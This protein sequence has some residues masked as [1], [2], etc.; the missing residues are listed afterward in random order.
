MNAE[1]KFKSLA[2]FNDYFRDEETCLAHFASIRFVNGEICPH[3]GHKH[4]HKFA[5]GKRYRCADCKK[6]FTIK[7]GT[8][9]G[10][11][12]L[13]LRK[14]FM[15]IYLLSTTSKGMSSVQLAKHV[16][17]TQTATV[18]TCGVTCGRSSPTC[19]TGRWRCCSGTSARSA[20]PPGTGSACAPTSGVAPA[21][22]R[23]KNAS[24]PEI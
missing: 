22:A 18:K 23:R 17:V 7:T 6:D 3:C 1:F 9:F 8:L 20:V 11:S 10:E 19:M 13:P 16:G 15:A 21:T 4:I 12:K 14:W 5:D 2:E 24:L